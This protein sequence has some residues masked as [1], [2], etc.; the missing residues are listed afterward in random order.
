MDGT[1]D[2]Q[3]TTIG[4]LRDVLVHDPEVE[5]LAVVGSGAGAQLDAWS[6][7]D[8]L[9]VVRPEAFAR[10]FPELDWLAALGKSYAF[11][12][13]REE[14]RAVSRVCFEDLRRLDVIVT[15]GEALLRSG[16]WSG[17]LAG[18]A[19][20]VFSRVPEIDRVLG[21][22]Y[23][24]PRPVVSDDAFEALANGFWFKA[25][26]AVQKVV[27][28]DLLVAL[29][30]SLELAQ[31]CCVLAMMLRDR[32]TGRTKHRDGV[33]DELVAELEGTVGAFTAAG[34]LESVERSAVVFDRLAGRWEAGYRERRG[35][36]MG[37]IE[38]ERVRPARVRPPRPPKRPEGT[39][40]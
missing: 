8:V 31:E 15:T 40:G 10:Y 21:G 5:A 39:R 14:T 1:T 35:P 26:V 17:L 3:E 27:R 18:G 20:V 34:I 30:L 32:E 28:G 13:H 11:E 36:L 37:W 9:I 4:E 19:R 38:A 22:S 25:V 7:L 2:W 33:G 16:D 12:Q 6:D 24:P 23:E 29:H